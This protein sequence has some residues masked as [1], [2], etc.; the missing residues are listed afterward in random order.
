MKKLSRARLSRPSSSSPKRPPQRKPRRSLFETLER[1]EVFNADPL[2]V[3]LVIS[4]QRDFFYQEY[5]DTKLSLEA[6]GLSVQVAATTTSPSTPHWDSGQTGDGIVTPDLALADVDAAEYSAIV[7]VGGWG[8]S[9]Y[10]YAFDGIYSDALYQGDLA[11]K[12]KV[13]DLINDFIDQDKY[14]SAICHATTVLAWARVDGVSPIAGKTVMTPQGGITQGGG[15]PV[16]W[17]GDYYGYYEF[18]QSTMM[19]MNGGITMPHASVGLPGTTADDVWVDGKII[20]AEDNYSALLFGQVIGDLVLADLAPEPPA[21][22]API[23]AAAEFDLNENS[24]SGTTVGSV[25][26]SD[27]DAGQSLT[28]AIVSGN[29]SG[30]FAINSATGELTV[31]DSG[32]LDFETS[33]VF[34]LIVRVTDNGAPALFVDAPVTVNLLDVNEIPANQ[35]PEIADQT[36]SIE[37]NP[38][39]GTTAGVVAATDADAGQTLSYAIVAGNTNAVFAIDSVTGE[40]NVVFPDGIDYETN[41]LFELT[42][43]VTD[44]GDPA[45][46]SEALVTVHVV[47]MNEAPTM[48]GAAFVLAENTAAGTVVGQIAGTD[49]DA[50]QTLTYS[51]VGGNAGGA[52]A[53]NA[54]TGQIVVANAAALDFETTPLFNLTVRATDNGSPQRSVDAAVTVQLTNVNETPPGPV[55]WSGPNVLVQATA[56]GEYIYVWTDAQGRAMAWIAGVNYGPFVLGPEGRVIVYG[57]GGDD[58]IFATGS[59]APVTIYGEAGFDVITGG[60]ADDVLDGGDGFDRITGHAGNDVILGGPWNDFLDGGDGDDIIVGGDGDDRIQGGTGNNL[61]IGGLGR[62]IILGGEGDDLL[63]GGTTS[64]DHQ[65]E[66]LRTILA[67][68]TRA[69]SLANRSNNLLAGVNGVRLALGETIQDDGAQDCLPS[70]NGVDW[71]FLQLGDYNCQFSASDLVTG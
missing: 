71:L 61:L 3:L 8:S 17:N 44:S 64:Y 14:V 54:A 45:L 42:V 52:F 1:R 65:T 9:M 35:A 4:D 47:N 53:V 58:W 2:P 66:A 69:D 51:I 60:R 28:Y 37:E 7:F 11:T 34:N 16:V 12:Q 6:K 10:Q 31:A 46:S 21:N 63:I 19:E 32:A 40:L 68:W 70:G 50:G 18:R 41:G 43:R 67:E 36:F 33:P 26:A 57:G 27:A 5:G 22:T 13:N 20:T 62:D 23:I 24:A 29:L 56:A 39:L 25:V 30:G 49:E 55:T 15:P 48:P 38:P 59:G